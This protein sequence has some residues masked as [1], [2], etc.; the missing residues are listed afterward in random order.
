MLTKDDQDWLA[1]LRGEAVPDA[2]ARTRAEVD[3][4]R[5]AMGELRTVSAQEADEPAIFDQ[6]AVWNRI[7][8]HARRTGTFP[9]AETRDTALA[10]LA[11]APIE[12]PLAAKPKPRPKPWAKWSGI[13]AA[14]AAAIWFLMQPALMGTRGDPETLPPIFR[15][16]PVAAARSL[17]N[18]LRAAGAEVTVDTPTPPPTTSVRLEVTARG[19]VSPGDAVDAVLER[20]GVARASRPR[21]V[22]DVKPPGP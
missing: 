21:F 17:A 15:H 8:A 18:D 3:Q 22:I 6:A 10:A 16:D 20:Y 5:A 9:A 7:S 1:L 13:G 14:I 12:V 2:S 11:P 19:R 4:W